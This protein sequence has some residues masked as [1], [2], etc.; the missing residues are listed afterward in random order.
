MQIHNRANIYQIATDYYPFGLEHQ[1]A[2]PTGTQGQGENQNFGF[3]GKEFH[4]HVN[5][6]D[7][8]ARMYDPTLGRWHCVDPLPKAHESLYAA[9]ANNPIC[10][11][12]LDGRDSI[13]FH[14]Y[15]NSEGTPLLYQEY[16][17]DNNPGLVTYGYDEINDAWVHEY[18]P[19]V[20]I[21]GMANT[22]ENK[23]SSKNLSLLDAFGVWS[24]GI[25]VKTRGNAVTGGTW[26]D[27]N[28]GK[29]M[30]KFIYNLN[31]LS[32]IPTIIDG[33]KTVITGSTLDGYQF[34]SWNN[35]LLYGGTSIILSVAGNK[36]GTNTVQDMIIETLFFD[37]MNTTVTN[38]AKEIDKK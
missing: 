31:P 9:F 15:Q 29:P 16:Y 38:T 32:S 14:Q 4:T 35:R 8:G 30:G 1:Q 3:N 34:N 26:A 20:V 13:N 24:Q 25:V 2:Q 10:N 33:A 7:Y 27:E 18:T 37:F 28:I 6:Y 22:E 12:D 11:I 21:I 19:P 5:W 36:T 23:E 17:V